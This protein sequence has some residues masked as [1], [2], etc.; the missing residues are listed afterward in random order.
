MSENTKKDNRVTLLIFGIAGFIFLVVGG[1]LINTFV[2]KDNS[3]INP[4]NDAMVMT[5]DPEIQDNLTSI[6]LA[7]PLSD[8]DAASFTAFQSLIILCQDYTPERRAQMQQHIDWLVDPS[9]I[10]SDIISAFGTNVQGTLLFGMANYTSIQWQLLEQPADS[11]LVRIGQ[12]L[13]VMLPA[14][15]QEPLGIYDEIT[16]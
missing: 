12:Q 4:I 3:S 16:P 8:A 9:G 14:F 10:P 7:T 1:L 5:I 6:P 11:C 2:L 15:D 13:D